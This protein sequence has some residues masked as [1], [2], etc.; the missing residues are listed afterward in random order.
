MRCMSTRGTGST[1]APVTCVDPKDRPL[2]YHFTPI[3][4]GGDDHW[5]GFL[6]YG[7]DM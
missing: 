3:T 7:Q 6:Q 5:I 4:V 2:G 1:T